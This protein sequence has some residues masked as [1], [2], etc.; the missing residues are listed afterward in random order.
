[1]IS[2]MKRKQLDVVR[3]LLVIYDILIICYVILCT[4]LLNYSL[5]KQSSDDVLE[6]SASNIIN[7]LP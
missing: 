7:I 1:M 6:I 3:D 5:V 2:Y 4:L